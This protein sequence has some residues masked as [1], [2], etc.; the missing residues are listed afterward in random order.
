MCK[1]LSKDSENGNK[2]KTVFLKILLVADELQL[3][4]DTNGSANVSNHR[5]YDGFL[6]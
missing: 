5:L 1:L 3:L 4:Q 2:T 6:K